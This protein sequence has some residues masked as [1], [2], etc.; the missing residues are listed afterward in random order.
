MWEQDKPC[1]QCN[2]PIAK[3]TP[4]GELYRGIVIP[5]VKLTPT[6]DRSYLFQKYPEYKYTET[7]VLFKK[8]LAAYFKTDSEPQL[9]AFKRCESCSINYL[10]NLN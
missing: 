1:K 10:N 6:L 9:I 4:T 7:L 2:D 8:P 5:S 3:Y